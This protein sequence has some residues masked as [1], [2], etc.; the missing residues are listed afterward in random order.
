LT[1]ASKKRQPHQA[2]TQSI[3]T[4][5]AVSG[6]LPEPF[7]CFFLRG[8]ASPSGGQL[9]QPIWPLPC[10]GR[11]IP[12]CFMRFWL[13]RAPSFR[14]A[15]AFDDGFTVDSIQYLE[16]YLSLP[17]APMVHL[18]SCR[19]LNLL[20]TDT[21]DVYLH[22]HVYTAKFRTAIRFSNL[23]FRRVFHQGGCLVS[24]SRAVG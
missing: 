12:R 19:L 20:P 9:S 11:N 10:R 21:H 18:A 24:I 3:N 22:L 13:W 2:L 6:L 4:D 16:M 14:F 23:R 15:A 7:P 17:E 8:Q 1:R 5:F